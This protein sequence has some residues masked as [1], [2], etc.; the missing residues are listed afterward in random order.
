MNHCPVYNAIGGHAYGSV[1]AGPIGAVL[2]PA[3]VGIGESSDLPN[4]SSF[5]GR[6]E[7]VCPV[8]IPL[9]DLMRRW[10][11][12]AFSGG[13]MRL[14]ARLLLRAWAYAAKRPRLYHALARFAAATLGAAGRSRGAFRLAATRARLDAHSRFSGT[15]RANL[16]A[17]LGRAP[18]G[19]AAM[20]RD[21]VLREIREAL[22]GRAEGERRLAVQQRLKAPPRH[23]LP[24][25]AMRPASQLTAQF[26][27]C[28]KEQTTAVIE[29]GAA[30]EILAAAAGFLA[31]AGAPLRLCIGAD[32]RLTAL[33]WEKSGG[34]VRLDGVAQAGDKAALSH[35]MAGVAE[36][37]TLV[38]ASG[39]E[40][41]TS[42]AFL[43]EIH[44][45]ALAR[46][47]IVGS[48][49][50]AFDMVRSRFGRGVMP[51]ALNLISG[52]SRTGDIGGRI[53]MG[54]H[55]P[56]T[57]CV[58]IYDDGRQ[59][60]L[61]IGH[62]VVLAAADGVGNAAPCLGACR[63]SLL[64]MQ[65]GEEVG[66]LRGVVSMTAFEHGCHELGLWQSGCGVG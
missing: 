66:D 65:D 62:A 48:Y 21:D 24:E 22:R 10:R 38:L 6:C 3:L 18:E 5:C 9:P 45:V 43:P 39:A 31:K 50:E 52:A 29:V 33:P 34:L 13:D 11:E 56:R 7:E 58:I 26:V 60:S 19:G 4:A 61:V 63:V 1:Y 27:S 28:L 41:P 23:Q 30:E 8:K 12:A 47:S 53:V 42:L 35:A 14:G 49:E 55:G 16:P 15:A 2:T 44:M 37:G 54:A 40:N 46:G 59:A 36:T 57:L 17:A 32:P 51:R 64:A 20:K 25:R